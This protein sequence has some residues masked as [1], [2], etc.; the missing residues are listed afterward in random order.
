MSHTAAPTQPTADDERQVNPIPD[1]RCTVCGQLVEEAAA[2]PH[3]GA[4]IANLKSE[5]SN[6]KSEISDPPAPI[7]DGVDVLSGLGQRASDEEPFTPAPPDP[8]VDVDDIAAAFG[9]L[10]SLASAAVNGSDFRPS[11]V[12]V[13]RE[14]LHELKLARLSIARFKARTAALE[15][16]RAQ[17][18]QM[19]AKRSAARSDTAPSDTAPPNATLQ[20]QLDN[21]TATLADLQ[22]A[23]AADQSE[24]SNLKSQISSC[25]MA[26]QSLRNAIDGMPEDRVCYDGRLEEVAM[27]A[28]TAIKRLRDQDEELAAAQRQSAH[29]AVRC[30]Q[31]S[32]TMAKIE[33]ICGQLVDAFGERRP[34]AEYFDAIARHA[35]Y[36][37]DRPHRS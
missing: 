5:I 25:N 31:F 7:D 4:A 15:A 12:S 33:A 11:D 9:R 22:A 19:R 13:V 18:L 21:A 23:R 6:L 1:S 29:D 34:F 26:L 37:L 35:R 27:D 2:C 24:I 10:E 30:Q 20:L 32:K 36:E 28:E 3:C 14:H 8:V 16:E 17:Y